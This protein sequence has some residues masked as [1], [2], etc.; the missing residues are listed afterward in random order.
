MKSIRRAAFAFIAAA[1][2]LAVQSCGPRGELANASAQAA[3]APSATQADAPQKPDAASAPQSAS[4]TPAT[5]IGRWGD[6]GD[7]SKD[8]VFNADGT[9]VS[10]TGGGGS[11]SLGGDRV[12][13]TGA[14]GSFEVRVE[15]LNP[16]T[17]MIFNPDGSFGTSQ[18]C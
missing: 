3:D 7:C 18:R 2:A 6:N 17:L 1:A 12:T 5:L 11:W 13:M 10:Y 4:L 16:Q 14:N 8:I 15:L 9:F